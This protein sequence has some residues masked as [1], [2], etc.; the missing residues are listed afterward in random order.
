MSASRPNLLV[1]FCDQ[2]RRDAIAAFG[3]DNVE[4]PHLD[5][6]VR[7]GVS[8]VHACSTYPICVPFRFT[9]MTGKYAHSRF[10]PGIEWRMS[11]AE[12]T[13]ADEFNNAGYESIY[14]G[15]WHLYGGHAL[16]PGHSARKANLTPVPRDHQG[17]WQKW[18]GFELRNGHFDTCYYEDDDPQP[19]PIET[20]QTDGLFDLAMQYIGNR[21]EPDR[22]F[23]CVISVEPPHFPY[24]APAELEAKWRDRPIT[25]PPSFC[26]RDQAERENFLARRRLYYAMVENLDQ[27]VGRLRTWLGETGLDSNTLVVF[28]SDHGEMG[29]CHGLPT[30]LK[31]YPY[32]ESVGI[33]LIICDPGQPDRAG[34]RL[35]TP[36][37]TEDLFPTLLGLCGLPSRQDLPGTDL[38][39]L[40]RGEIGHL[41]RPGVL[42]EYVAETRAGSPFH[43]ETWRGFRS[44]RFKYTV[45]GDVNGGTPWQFFDLQTDPFEMNNLVRDPAWTAEIARHH[46]WMRARMAETGDLYILK[47]AWGCDGLNLWDV[48]V[49]RA[50]TAHRQPSP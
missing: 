47:P 38:A 18:L 42:L 50:G 30:A 16:L 24:E 21:A 8:F 14:L 13:L 35:P 20:Y 37:C 27:N 33:P 15:K 12:R 43:Y 32:E 39:P 2:L 41:A 23:G 5:Q 19:R 46:E 48:A 11:P 10:V 49:P 44:E 31:Q 6:M 9:L 25:V 17:R 3:D 36:T 29:G 28:F 22:P 45:L 40:I 7:D 26:A 1:I 4:T 34:I